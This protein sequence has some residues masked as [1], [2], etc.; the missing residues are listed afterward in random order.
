MQIPTSAG[1]KR[2][3]AI[4]NTKKVTFLPDQK[5]VEVEEGVTL[6]TAAEQAGVHLNS[7]CGGEGV[8]AARRRPSAP[9]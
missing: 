1:R 5:E 9:V 2:K 4:M 3:E 8:C 6:F 7:L